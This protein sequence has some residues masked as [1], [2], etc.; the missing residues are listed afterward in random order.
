MR[1]FF[2]FLIIVGGVIFWYQQKQGGP[3]ADFKNPIYAEARVTAKIDGRNIENVF[4]IQTASEDECRQS[5]SAFIRSL[6]NEKSMPLTLKSS[7]CKPVLSPLYAKLFDNQPIHTTYISIARGAN[8]EREAR[9]LF[10]GLSLDESNLICDAWTTYLPNQIKLKGD[11]K[12]IR[13][14]APK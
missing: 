7:N 14:F 1:N 4:L 2:I 8:K 5:G 10:W 3:V 12:C 11:V 13:G 6:Q 9:I